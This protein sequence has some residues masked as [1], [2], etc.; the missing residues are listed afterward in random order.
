MQTYMSKLF[1]KVDALIPLMFTEF[2]EFSCA[3][4]SLTDH[5]I[6]L[7]YPKAFQSYAI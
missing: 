7:I 2:D 6:A 4:E 5:L 1:Q 3:N